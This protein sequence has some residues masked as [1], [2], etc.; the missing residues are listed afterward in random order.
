MSRFLL[1][2][3]F[4]PAGIALPPTTP[5]PTEKD[6]VYADAFLHVTA[7]NMHPM[8]RVHRLG[9]RVVVLCGHPAFQGRIHDAGA[10]RHLQDNPDPLDFARGLNGSFLILLYDPRVPELK[11]MTDR[12]AS[13]PFYYRVQGKR[14]LGSSS[15]TELFARIEKPVLAPSAFFEFLYF[16][17]L[18]GEKTYETESRFLPFASVL[19]AGDGSIRRYWHPTFTKSTLTLEKFATELS[20]RLRQ[21]VALYQSDERQYGLML[22]GGLDSRAILAATMGKIVCFTNCPQRNNEYEVAAELTGI[23][24]VPH[25]FI[26]R[27][28]QYLNNRIDDAVYISGG[29]TNHTE[30]QFAGYE[31]DILPAAHAVFLGL[32]LDIMFCGHYLPKAPWRILG[33]ESCAFRLRGID[34]DLAGQFMNSISYRLKTSDPWS[35]VR[36]E[37]QQELRD[38]L[39]HSVEERLKLG[40]GFGAEGYDQWEFMHLHNFARHYSFQMAFSLHSYVDYR[41]P[42]MENDLYDLCLAMPVDYKVNWRAYQMAIRQLNP[43]MMRVRNANHNLP[44]DLSLWY[45]TAMRWGRGAANR[46]FGPRWRSMPRNDDRSWPAARDSIDM[47]PNIQDM[48]R[49]L[50]DSEPLAALGLFEMDRVRTMVGEHM[51]GQRDHCG[52][53]NGLLTINRFLLAPGS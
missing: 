35:I 3:T 30:A 7:V 51:T 26:P 37:R 2:V 24:G 8:P 44:A 16:R 39:R 43:K 12:F 19:S 9:K 5:P 22:S 4:D 48:V 29:M 23:A 17:R 10:L 1:A 49:A 28:V 25:H 27:P 36:P 50:P 38:K 41:I 14:L 13:R 33:T 20:H 15:F 53:L 18:F 45:A 11:I 47:N 46:L 6:A 40:R 52:L 34:Q 32:A 42:A 31:Q 21:S